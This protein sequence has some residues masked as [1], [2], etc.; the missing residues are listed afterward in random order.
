MGSS[1]PTLRK[2]LPFQKFP[3]SLL[4]WKQELC[5]FVSWRAR[6]K[7][8]CQESSQPGVLSPQSCGACLDYHRVLSTIRDKCSDLCTRV[9]SDLTIIYLYKVFPLSRHWHFPKETH[10]RRV[11][12][13]I[14]P[15]ISHQ[16]WIPLQLVEISTSEEQFITSIMEWDQLLP[17]GTRCS[18]MT[19]S[20]ES[21]K[22]IFGH[23][24]WGKMNTAIW[25]V[26][27]TEDGHA[28]SLC[29]G[30]LRGIP[31]CPAALCTRQLF[32]SLVPFP[33]AFGRAERLHMVLTKIATSGEKLW[34]KNS[35]CQFFKVWKEP[36]HFQTPIFLSWRWYRGG[37]NWR[38][39]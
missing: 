11:I 32:F 10:F 3:L 36:L 13:F 16:G 17:R 5:I 37:G 33:A 19:P 29:F 9:R 23:L 14:S 26:A 4:G 22:F 30:L 35:F 15:T 7:S 1:F 2:F 18:Q 34:I 12:G 27:V 21:R 6:E 24:T 8:S 25:N 20:K 39:H 28:R 31:A 38:H